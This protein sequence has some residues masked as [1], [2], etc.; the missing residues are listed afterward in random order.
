MR[1]ASDALSGTLVRSCSIVSDLCKPANLATGDDSGDDEAGTIV[2]AGDDEMDTEEGLHHSCG[3][4]P[5]VS[6]TVATRSANESCCRRVLRVRVGVSNSPSSVSMGLSSICGRGAAGHMFANEAIATTTQ[7]MFAN[8]VCIDPMTQIA[9]V[10][11]HS[12]RTCT[13]HECATYV[14][15][16]IHAI[17]T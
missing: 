16:G 7:M 11:C 9:S 4:S 15:K 12:H 1:K 17:N 14:Y 5:N 3:P 2:D 10:T 8:E 13:Q 6:M